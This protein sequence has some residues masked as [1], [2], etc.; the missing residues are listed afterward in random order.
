MTTTA[1]NKLLVVADET[2]DSS[3]L[4]Q[5]VRDIALARDADVL[6]VVPAFN[7]RLR[8]WM[9]DSDGAHHAAAR[10]L[11]G[12]LDGL[13][14]AGVRVRGEVGD[15]NPMHAIED[16]MNTI[17]AE[18]II[19]STHPEGRSNWL[20]HDLVARVCARFDVPVVHLVGGQ[21]TQP[22]LWA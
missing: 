1:T 9:S 11:A 12:C 21:A 15:A 19:I 7:T 22:C 20:A 16:A 2:V 13:L 6:V 5:A 17:G 10:R 4:V 18:E 14:E 3:V 8:H